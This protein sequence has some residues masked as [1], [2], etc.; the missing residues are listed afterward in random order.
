MTDTLIASRSSVVS[1]SSD[2]KAEKSSA[3]GRYSVAMTIVSAN[4]M[5]SVIARSSRNG[6]SGTIIITTTSTT[7]P[8]ASRSRDFESRFSRFTGQPSGRAVDEGEHVGDGLVEL[9]GDQVADLDR[10]VQRARERRV[11]DDRDAGR[12]GPPRGCARAMWSMPLATTSGA[13]LAAS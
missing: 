12:H 5:L 10:R 3:R 7:A 9:L 1:S 6:G 11:G 4:E 2:G 13:P 8:A